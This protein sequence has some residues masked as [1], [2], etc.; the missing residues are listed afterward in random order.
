MESKNLSFPQ[1]QK[2]PLFNALAL[3]YL[4]R[5][6][7]ASTLNITMTFSFQRYYMHTCAWH[8]MISSEDWMGYDSRNT[9]FSGNDCVVL[10]ENVEVRIQAQNR[11]LN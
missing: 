4:H 2:K 8:E 7:I 9:E 5:Y 11:W 1:M 10:D 6:L 3:C